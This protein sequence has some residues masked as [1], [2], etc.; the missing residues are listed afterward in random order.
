MCGRAYSTYTD[1]ELLFRYLNER[2][3]PWPVD[4]E[5][6]DFKSNYN[7]CPSHLAL[8][9]S[10]HNDALT[11]RKMRWGL[12]PSWAKSVKDADKYSMINAKSEEIA[13]KRS[14]KAAF[15]KRRCIVPVSG[16][17][18]WDRSDGVK[19]PYAIFMKSDPIM[20][21][22]GIWESWEDAASKAVVDSFSVLTKDSN[23]FMAGIH[24][25]MPVILSRR[26]EEVWLNPKYSELSE[27]NA[28]M[29]SCTSEEMD[30]YEVSSL[31]NSPKNNSVEVLKRI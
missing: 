16:F 19:R 13:E 26:E 27:L 25:R 21:I 18:E 12:V 30:A 17:Y 1:D 31:V 8:T 22:A 24:H 11:F 23:S 6:P 3:W 15:Q 14:Y 20:S 28:V 4:E 9:L 10:V 7:I 5:I 2:Q 29:G